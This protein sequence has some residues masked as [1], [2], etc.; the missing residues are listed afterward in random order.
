FRE[1]RSRVIGRAPVRRRRRRARVE[2]DDL[3]AI[4]ARLPGLSLGLAAPDVLHPAAPARARV[5]E[6][7]LRVGEREGVLERVRRPAAA[8][9]A[10]GRQLDVGS[11]L[12]D[13]QAA[14][15]E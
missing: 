15:R 13:G 7:V 1:L 4:V 2:A 3:L 6:L 14:R 8:E 5:V 11:F 10:L 12:A 9:I